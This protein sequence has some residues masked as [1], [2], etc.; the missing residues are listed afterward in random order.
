MRLVLLLLLAGTQSASAQDTPLSAEAFESY[1]EGK[2][3]S[4]STGGS[5]YGVEAY[6]RNRRVQWSYLDGECTYG[7]WYPEG[8][9]ICFVY[10]DLLA[11]PQCWEFFLRGGR[12]TARFEGD[13]QET[14]FY[15]TGEV[16]D[17]MC[18]G[19]DVGV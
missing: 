3:L 10:E 7:Y 8:Q 14:E 4:Y 16:D 15:E 17:M 13:P 1:V 12:L 9:Q 6:L 18:L 19:P 5:A 11:G 2:T